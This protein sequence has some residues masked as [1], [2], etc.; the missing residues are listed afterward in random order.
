MLDATVIISWSL[1]IFAL[2]SIPFCTLFLCMLIKYRD[3]TEFNHAYYKILMSLT[4]ADILQLTVAEFVNQFLIFHGWVAGFCLNVLGD[5]GAHVITM[6]FWGVGPLHF[7]IAISMA[8]N[9]FTAYV[10]P[11]RFKKVHMGSA[12]W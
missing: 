1:T 8:V 2:V 12:R 11:L 10:L 4:V 6:I 5:F 7:S 3:T 9:R